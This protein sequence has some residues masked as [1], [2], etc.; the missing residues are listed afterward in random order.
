MFLTPGLKIILDTLKLIFRER[1]RERETCLFVQDYQAK[2]EGKIIIFK[3][4]I[5]KF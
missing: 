3:K 1:E 5:K 4:R 2:P